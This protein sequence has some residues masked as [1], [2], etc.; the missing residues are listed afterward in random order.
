[1]NSLKRTIVSLFI[2]AITLSFIVPLALPSNG[3]SA[4]TA[5]Y[6]IDAVDHQV[7]VMYS[8][9]IVVIDTIYVSGGVTDGFTVGLPYRYSA[10]V[11]KVIAYD[12]NHI[13]DVDLG[14][15]LGNHSGFYGAKVDF[16]GDSPSVFTVAFVLSNN[17]VKE[18]GSGFTLDFPA[19]PSLAQGVG[20]VNTNLTFPSSPSTLTIIK[21]DGSTNKAN[22]VKTNLPAYVYSIASAIVRM[23]NKTL[24]LSTIDNLNRQID[25]DPNG[26]VTAVDSYR[27]ISNSTSPLNAFVLSLPL[28][29]TDVVVKDQSEEAL[30]S[31]EKPSANVLLVNATLSEAINEGQSTALTIYYNLP[32]ATIQGSKY[33]L[34][35]FQLFPHFQ[36]L[37]NKQL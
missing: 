16:N 19:Y 26:I 21:D 14:V 32:E 35:S 34:S 12:A 15:Q 8:G 25:I 17:L 24:Q 30:L 37:L 29:A 4:Q 31:H 20:T 1:M 5:S 27:I 18:T 7:Q 22:Y 10:D 13:F 6:S 33:S 28:E 36:Y 2:L 3:V 23:P 11:L 9:N